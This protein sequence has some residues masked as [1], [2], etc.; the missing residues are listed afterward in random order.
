MV[1]QLAS[2]VSIDVMK[3][4]V[5]EAA[6]PDKAIVVLGSSSEEEAPFNH[7]EEIDDYFFDVN[8]AAY[9]KFHRPHWPSI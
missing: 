7:D 8:R 2:S 6:N 3:K 4:T 9:R 1:R 5:S